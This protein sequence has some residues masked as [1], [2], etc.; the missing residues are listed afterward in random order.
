MKIWIALAAAFMTLAMG[1]TPV[2]ARTVQETAAGGPVV[3]LDIPDA[4]TSSFDSDGNLILAHPQGD[5]AFSVTVAPDNRDLDTF[6]NEVWVIINASMQRV[7]NAQ[8]GAHTGGRYRGTFVHPTSGQLNLETV[9]VK[10]GENWVASITLVA[11]QTASQTSLD[12]G[13]MVMDSARIISGEQ[14]LLRH[15]R[16]R[17]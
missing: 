6:M 4:W 12:L 9:A 8:I 10:V 5:L 13:R 2:S 11:P 14:K 17:S 16:K 7:D 1:A 15:Q 3:E